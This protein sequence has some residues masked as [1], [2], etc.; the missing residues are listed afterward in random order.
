M[1]AEDRFGLDVLPFVLNHLSIHQ[2]RRVRSITIGGKVVAERSSPER[3]KGELQ[4]SRQFPCLVVCFW[5]QL[6]IPPSSSNAP[7]V[8]D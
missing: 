4:L 3:G 7:F 8:R 5:R 1:K 2:P 6:A